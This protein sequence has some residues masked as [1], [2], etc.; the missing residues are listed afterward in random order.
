MKSH[1]GTTPDA[2]MRYFDASIPGHL[3]SLMAAALAPATP[4]VRR[5]D[6]DD[7]RSTRRDA[8]SRDGILDRLD[9]WFW[10]QELKARDA[11]LSQSHDVF[12][13]ERRIAALERGGISRYY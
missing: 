5:G 13:L 9:R 1:D 3:F 2:A 4:P 8:A 11:Y 7:R 10:R 6:A 12:D